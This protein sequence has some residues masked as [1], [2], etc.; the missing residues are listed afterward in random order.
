MG[1]I[2]KLSK[3]NGPNQNLEKPWSIGPN[4]FSPIASP[5]S[6]PDMLR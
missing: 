4:S 5:T 1:P 2:T 6:G 3:A